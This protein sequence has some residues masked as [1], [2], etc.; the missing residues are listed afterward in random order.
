LII[1]PFEDRTLLSFAAAVSYPVDYGAESVAVGDFNGD[2]KLDLVVANY[3]SYSFPGNSDVSVLMGNGDG[4]F[5]PARNFETGP[6]STPSSVAVGDF[7]GNGKLDIVETNN[8]GGSVLLGN[9]DGTFQPA[10]NFTLPSVAVPGYS[11]TQLPTSVA[12]GDLNGDGK[13]DLV[14]TGTANNGLGERYQPSFDF[15]NVLLSNGDGT[16]RDASTVEVPGGAVALALGDFLGNGKLDVATTTTTGVALLLNRGDG[17]LGAPTTFAT[18]GTPQSVVVGDLNGDGKLDVVTANYNPTGS[19]LSVLPGNGD[20]TFQAA[21][22]FASGDNLFELTLADFNHDGKL[23]I[24]GINGQGSVGVLLGNGDGTF[25][26]PLS[27]AAGFLGTGFLA[28]GDFNGDGYPDLAVADPGDAAGVPST[29]SILVNA[30]DWSTPQA[31][32]FAL[33]GFA[34]PTTAGTANTFTVT[35]QTSNGSTDTNYTGTVHFTS[36]DPQAVLPA[37]YTFTAADAG[38][39]TFSATLKAAGKQSITATDTASVGLSGTLGSVTVSPAAAS[40]FRIIGFPPPTT[41][42]DLGSIG[43]TAFDPYGNIAI[44]Y[45]G[46]VHFTSSDRQA[47]LPANY[48][49]TASDAGVHSFTATLK[50]AG[51]QSITATDT[52]TASVSGTEGGITVNPA[53]ASKFILTAPAGV[54]AGAPFSLTLTVEDAY[55]NIVTNYA[56]TVSFSSSDRKASLPSYYTFRATDHGVHTFSMVL[57]TRGNQRITIVDKSKSSLTGSVIVDVL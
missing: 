8:D 19:S 10:K 18:A 5:Q 23:D 28:A 35:V 31:S 12:V 33:S 13:L 50:T 37:D 41:A 21:H 15:V 20:G 26:H 44:G 47:S 2:G 1:E 25:Q 42:G 46:T 38:V 40:N 53:A 55:G 45:A 27:Y 17:T 52:T 24:A 54:A 7:T 3:F 49:F 29:V 36:S 14:V 6:S 48:T 16:F 4:T 22:T 32:N 11:G 51:T 30:A 43:V 39:H 34:S 9:G 57:R 56:G